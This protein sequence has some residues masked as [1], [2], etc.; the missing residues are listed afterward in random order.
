MAYLP[1]EICVPLTGGSVLLTAAARPGEVSQE[2]C[3][4]DSIFFV[5]VPVQPTKMRFFQ[6]NNK[7]VTNIRPE[8]LLTKEEDRLVSE[9]T[10]SSKVDD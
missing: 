7:R 2:R 9:R 6:E 1:T 10:T 8:K 5:G 3:I 4:S